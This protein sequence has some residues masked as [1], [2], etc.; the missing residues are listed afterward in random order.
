MG[1]HLPENGQNPALYFTRGGPEGLREGRGE[2]RHPLVIAQAGDPLEPLT[3]RFGLSRLIPTN[4]FRL[5]REGVGGY[6]P[7]GLLSALEWAGL[8]R[9]AHRRRNLADSEVMR[10]LRVHRKSL[11]S[12]ELNSTDIPAT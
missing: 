10:V 11:S 7:P 3:T 4:L 2:V 5:A 12:G 9:P 8:T 6:S 1:A